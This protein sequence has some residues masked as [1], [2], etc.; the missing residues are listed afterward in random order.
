MIRVEKRLAGIREN[1]YLCIDIEVNAI[2]G[3]GS[4]YLE[5]VSDLHSP[6]TAIVTQKP[7]GEKGRPSFR[8]VVI[9]KKQ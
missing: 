3:C 5:R 7:S 8:E 9:S 2:A 1:E 4:A 6:C